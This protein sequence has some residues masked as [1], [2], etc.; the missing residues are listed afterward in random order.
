MAKRQTHTNRPGAIRRL[1]I[2]AAVAL[3]IATP[4]LAI[5]AG[6]VLDR[7]T[8]DQRSGYLSGAVE[9]A[10]F[11]AATQERNQAKSDC[12]RNWYFGEGTGSAR[13]ILAVFE[14][15]R[16]REAMPLIM[17]VINRHCGPN[18]GRR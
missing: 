12:I 17:I 16:K 6:D 2:A 3:F 8:L 18:A 10:M 13:E 7:M 4:A 11:I 15:N 5:P 14:A 1:A 9:M